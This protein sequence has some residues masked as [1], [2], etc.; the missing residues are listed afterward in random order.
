MIPTRLRRGWSGYAGPARVSIR[1]SV[2]KKCY[3]KAKSVI[4]KCYAKVLRKS[5][6]GVAGS[7]AACAAGRGGERPCAAIRMARQ[8]RA[9]RGSSDSRAEI[10]ERRRRSP[11]TPPVPCGSSQRESKLRMRRRTPC[12]R[13]LGVARELE[14]RRRPDETKYRVRRACDTARFDAQLAWPTHGGDWRGGAHG[15]RSRLS[16]SAKRQHRDLLQLAASCG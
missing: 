14:S 4:K 2:S 7:R 13:D 1:K 12:E 15:A 5:Q 11:F 16:V 10:S 3:E 8:K 9:T 6:G